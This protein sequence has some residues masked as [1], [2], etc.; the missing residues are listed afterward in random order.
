MFAGVKS[1]SGANSVTSEEP[2]PVEVYTVSDAPEYVSKGEAVTITPVVVETKEEYFV[3][4]LSHNLQDYTRRLCVEYNVPFELAIAVMDHESSFRADAV[5][6]TN[7]YGI[8]QIN[9]V[10][11]SRLIKTLGISDFLSPYDN[12]HAGVYMLAEVLKAADGDINFAMIMYNC[13][14][15][16]ARAKKAKGITSTHYSESI[17]KLYD[18]YM[19]ECEVVYE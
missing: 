1:I 16:G 19:N 17:C 14:I 3:I 12:I 18:Y 8:M 2:I 15:G 4:P 7:D 9:K 10:N 13:G 5:S 6:K 11:H